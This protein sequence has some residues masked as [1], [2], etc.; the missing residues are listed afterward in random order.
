ME[1][2]TFFLD[3]NN[4]N[5]ESNN[6]IELFSEESRDG[7]RARAFEFVQD[8]DTTQGDNERVVQ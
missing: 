1:G 4:Q 2:R 8:D 3:L 5:S 6:S 7:L